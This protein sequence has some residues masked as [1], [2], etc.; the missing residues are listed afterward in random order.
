MNQKLLSISILIALSLLM[1][2]PAFAQGT[3]ST[4]VSYYECAAPVAIGK[5]WNPDGNFM[6]RDVLYES[7]ILSYSDDRLSGTIYGTEDVVIAHKD[8]SAIFKGTA[9]I[10]L[11]D[12]RGVW[13]GS[14]IGDGVFGVNWR[15]NAVLHGI[16]GEVEGLKAFITTTSDPS[17]WCANSTGEIMNPGGK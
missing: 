13:Y 11:P 8:G 15:F 14:W 7:A 16:S 17:Y 10:V 4:P 9:R 12:D 2:A 1:A 6:M 5:A 3:T